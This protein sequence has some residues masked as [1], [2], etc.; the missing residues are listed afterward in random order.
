MAYAKLKST[1]MKIWL[2]FVGVIGAKYKITQYRKKAY[3]TGLFLLS[4]NWIMMAFFFSNNSFAYT[5]PAGYFVATLEGTCFM[6]FYAMILEVCG[7]NLYTIS[8]TAYMISNSILSF[9][10]PSLIPD[11]SYY[12][13]Y[14][15]CTGILVLCLALA[16]YFLIIETQGLER[17]DVWDILRKRK[18]R[19]KCLQD[20]LEE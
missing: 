11:K 9:Y 8:L 14:C 12:S 4:F 6:P 3:C 16:G 18:T 5:I 2:I 13:T 15:F 17:K 19:G 20:N 7:E 1:C 10:S